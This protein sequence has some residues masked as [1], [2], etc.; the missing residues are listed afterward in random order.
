VR[1]RWPPQAHSV[2]GLSPAENGSLSL[3]G[4]LK[5][6]RCPIQ[7]QLEL[8]EPETSASILWLFQSKG[9]E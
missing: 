4:A 2:K 8:S 6:I 7:G 5:S 9:K 1:H 3:S